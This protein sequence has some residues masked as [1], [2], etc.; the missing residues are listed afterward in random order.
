MSYAAFAKRH[1]PVAHPKGPNRP[2]KQRVI[3]ELRPG[4][5][6]CYSFYNGIRYG[7]IATIDGTNVWAHWL[8]PD[9]SLN[10]GWMS[11]NTVHLHTGGIPTGLLGI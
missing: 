8:R 11:M 4:D 3:G 9:G 6:I 5:I 2:V 7:R 10:Y 1:I